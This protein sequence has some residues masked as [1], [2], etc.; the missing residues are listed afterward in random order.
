MLYRSKLLGVVI[1]A[2]GNYN[3]QAKSGKFFE[4]CD[5]KNEKTN[6]DIF[7]FLHLFE[8]KK[9]RLEIVIYHEIPVR[10]PK[11]NLQLV[12]YYSKHPTL[13]NRYRSSFSHL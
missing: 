4:V 7:E 5:Q 13:I 8:N 11:L 3:L 6:F 9:N 2:A 12:C 1:L 10:T